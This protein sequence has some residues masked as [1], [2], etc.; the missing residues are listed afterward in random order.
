MGEARQVDHVCCFPFIF[1]LALRTQASAI[2]TSSSS[3]AVSG[4]LV[5]S[6][7]DAISDRVLW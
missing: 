1:F 2:S 7:I 4:R 6:L 3:V 5:F